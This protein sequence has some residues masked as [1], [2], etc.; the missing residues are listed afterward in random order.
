MNSFTGQGFSQMLTYVQPNRPEWCELKTP[1]IIDVTDA[2]MRPAVDP[3]RDVL[4]KIVR[5]GTLETGPFPIG[6]DACGRFVEIGNC[7]TDIRPGHRPKA[8]NEKGNL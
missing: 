5:G 7:M 3:H 1:V 2:I 6:Q 8:S 4:Q